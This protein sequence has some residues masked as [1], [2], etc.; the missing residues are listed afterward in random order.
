MPRTK[1]QRAA[2]KITTDALEA[3]L[4]LVNTATETATR[5]AAT[6]AETAFRLTTHEEV[7]AERLLRIDGRFTG[8]ET[9]IKSLRA[10]I[11]WGG[12]L[13]VGAVGALIVTLAV[14]AWAFIKKEWHLP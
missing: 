8:V 14:V 7:C 11:L 1:V 3:A 5:L 13:A 4:K 10:I 2:D 12:G 9:S 6:A